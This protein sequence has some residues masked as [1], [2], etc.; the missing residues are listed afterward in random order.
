MIVDT[1]GGPMVEPCL[2]SLAHK[3]RLTEI[4][5]P[6]KDRQVCLD[7]I[8]FYHREAR[9]LGV[10][11]RVLDARACAEILGKLTPGFESGALRAPAA[12]INRHPLQEAIKA[13]EQVLNRSVTGKVTLTPNSI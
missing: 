13:Y 7:L 9:L 3:G 12:G 2:K 5:A 8:D 1:V 11:S 6:A 4:S 10:D